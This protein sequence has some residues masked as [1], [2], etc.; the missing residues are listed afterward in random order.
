MATE[1][2]PRAQPQ[3]RRLLRGQCGAGAPPAPSAGWS[4][5][6]PRRPRP[7]WPHNPPRCLGGSQGPASWCPRS[8]SWGHAMGQLS[9]LMGA[10]GWA[11]P[12]QWLCPQWGVRTTAPPLCP[13]SPGGC[14]VPQGWSTRSRGG[15]TRGPTDH[16]GYWGEGCPLTAPLPVRPGSGS[17]IPCTES[18]C[19]SLTG[20]SLLL[21]WRLSSGWPGQ[22]GAPAAPVALARR[23]C[24]Q[25]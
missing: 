9:Q 21:R 25:L 7:A 8:A 10:H 5:P 15:L 17:P 12:A 4:S 20:L 13:G 16:L 22:S 18:V 19:L 11:L 24:P 14:A 6:A 2:S 1:S 23:G 3:T